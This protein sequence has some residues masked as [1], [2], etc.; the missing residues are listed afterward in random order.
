MTATT[1]LALGLLALGLGLLSPA[2]GWAADP[3]KRPTVPD[4]TPVKKPGPPPVKEAWKPLAETTAQALQLEVIE[5]VANKADPKKF[6]LAKPTEFQK[7]VAEMVDGMKPEAKKKALAQAVK[8]ASAPA[9]ERGTRFTRLPTVT[10]NGQTPVADQLAKLTAARKALVTRKGLDEV[11]G[12]DLLKELGDRKLTAKSGPPANAVKTVRLELVEFHVVDDTTG[13]GADD[14]LMGGTAVNANG[15]TAGVK[16]IP[17]GGKE[18]DDGEKRTY[19]PARKVYDF[20]LP[21][22]GDY[23]KRVTF[24]VLLVE[25]DGGGMIQKVVGQLTS[26]VKAMVKDE[27]AKLAD[28]TDQKLKDVLNSDEMAGI[29]SD[30]TAEVLGAV[31]DTI[32]ALFD[33]LFEDDLFDPIPVELVVKHPAIW[34]NG[35][36]EGAVHTYNAYGHGGHWK[37][38]VRWR[39]VD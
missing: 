29:L 30:V 25:E 10:P 39:K 4:R 5:A 6:P 31:V 1:R 15:N 14:I 34:S 12:G 9:A 28:E 17:L 2:R 33:Q 26:K 38:K 20:K 3:P 22:T 19:T 16:S 21:Q 18:F 32:F 36:T 35:A 8:M 13:W 7:G 37:F 11:A 23:P 24:L 27:A